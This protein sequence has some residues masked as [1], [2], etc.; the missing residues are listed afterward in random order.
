MCDVDLGS[1]MFGV[2]E[3]V[4]MVDRE[5]LVDRDQEELNQD[6]RGYVSDLAAERVQGGSVSPWGLGPLGIQQQYTFHVRHAI[7]P[8]R[9]GALG[10]DITQ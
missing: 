4:E 6:A 10:T 5:S 9:P 3:M 8:W 2:V 7:P 1:D